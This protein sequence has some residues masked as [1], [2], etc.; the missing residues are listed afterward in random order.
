VDVSSHWYSISSDPNPNWSV[1]YAGRDEIWQYQKDVVQRNGLRPHIELNRML[2]AANWD[3]E[4][5]GYELHIERTA[6]PDNHRTNSSCSIVGTGDVEVVFVDILIQA[7]GGS[8]SVPK[9]PTSC[10]L[11]GLEEFRGV[12]FHSAAWRTDVNLKNKRVGV[13]GN[14]ASACQIVPAISEEPSTQVVNFGK[15]PQWFAARVGCAAVQPWHH[16]I[17]H[18]YLIRHKPNTADCKNGSSKIYL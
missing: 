16:D 7:V 6:Q 11:P 17:Q 4:R 3:D 12:V 5:H 8:W 13:I 18:Q 14:G 10:D 9:L 1:T 15:T 2:I